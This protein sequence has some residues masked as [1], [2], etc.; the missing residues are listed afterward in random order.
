MKK[1]LSFINKYKFI[2]SFTLLTITIPFFLLLI[3]RTLQFP[4]NFI[5]ALII[6]LLLL[7]IFGHNIEIRGFKKVTLILVLALIG[8]LSPLLLF[9]ALIQS[10]GQKEHD[11][12]MYEICL[13]E[14]RK[15]YK[16]SVEDPLPQN[17]LDND[18][19]PKWWYQ[20]SECERNIELGYGPIFSE[21]PPGFYPVKKY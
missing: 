8:V 16:V 7:L 17:E 4:K 12:I 2:L 15:Y 13:P 21:N 9:I 19:K 14:L 5:E 10:P 1:I 11:R 3:N 20:H 18:G 6:F